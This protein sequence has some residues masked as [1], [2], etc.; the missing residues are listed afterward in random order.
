MQEPEDSK[1]WYLIVIS[2][3]AMPMF[4]VCWDSGWLEFF[5]RV[6]VFTWGYVSMWNYQVGLGFVGG[7]VFCPLA[8]AAL[9]V[10]WVMLGLV[11][12]MNIHHT[13]MKPEDS[14][15]GLCIACAVLVFQIALPIIVF[16]LPIA[17]SYF[18]TLIVPIP[19]P[20]IFAV[21]SH[22]TLYRRSVRASA[23]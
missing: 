3:F 22:A 15:I 20:S 5:D 6:L 11:L 2:T 10:T 18:I 23:D 14:G 21:W 17:P 4:V 8:I 9:T 1:K 7:G 12:A 13:I 16:S 19:V